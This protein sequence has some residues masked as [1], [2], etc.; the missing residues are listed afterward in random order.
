MQADGRLRRQA[1]GNPLRPV[2]GGHQRRVQSPQGPIVV[3]SRRAEA[4]IRYRTLAT[5]WT[6]NNL[7]D[8]GSQ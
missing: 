8:V 1:N 2:E 5:Q 7:R 4:L 6:R 3:S